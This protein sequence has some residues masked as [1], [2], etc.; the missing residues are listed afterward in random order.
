M[1]PGRAVAAAE[2]RLVVVEVVDHEAGLG[3]ELGH[4]EQRERAAPVEQVDALADQGRVADAL[5]DVVDAVGQAEV[6]DRGDRVVDG[7]RRR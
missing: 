4:A 2:D 5:E 7:A 1:G 6:L 3:A